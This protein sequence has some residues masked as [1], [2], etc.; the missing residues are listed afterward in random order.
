MFIKHLEK[1]VIIRI[2][3]VEFCVKKPLKCFVPTLKGEEPHREFEGFYPF[4][5]RCTLWRMVLTFYFSGWIFGFTPA[6][7]YGNI[8]LCFMPI[9]HHK[10][11]G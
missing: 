4:F 8:L 7:D 11:T 10:R 5:P 2:L 6:G 3:S 9:D 1:S